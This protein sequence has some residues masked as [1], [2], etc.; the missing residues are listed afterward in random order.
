[1][2][3][4]RSTFL[5]ATAIVAAAI[6]GVASAN[7]ETVLRYSNWV[8]ATHPIVTKVIQPWGEE[9]KAATEGRVSVEVVPALGPPPGHF[10]LV[11]NEVADMAFGVHGY[12]PGR[13]TLT[14][15]VEFPGMGDSAEAMSVA[16]Q[17]IH[18]REL[19]ATNEHDGVKLLA[20]WVHGPGNIYNNQRAVT[21]VE[22]L[23]GLK[24]R[25]GGGV[26][27]ETAQA[28]G[29]TPLLRPSTES[30]E[31]ISSGIADGVLFP[32][33]SVEAFNLTKVIDHATEVPGGLYNV[34]FAM[35]MNQ[36]TFDGLSAADQDAVMS[37]SGEALARMAG[38][39][40]DRADAKA[41][42]TM[43][44]AGVQTVNAD[45]SFMDAVTARTQPLV[46]KWVE[47]AKAKGVDG[48]AM[49]D[50]YRAEIQSVT[51]GN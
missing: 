29:I 30:Y 46:A 38:Q 40:W 23:A 20:L 49:L 2:S 44:E 27:A 24:M 12:T 34:S 13:F 14:K 1:M 50:A 9:L 31:L 5:A 11:A 8:P 35:F 19:A 42:E 3:K 47:D 18:E 36:D 15:M 16:Y 41:R 10:D 48:Q 32:P 43:A 7:A 45:Q 17:R 6:A 33:E 37:V 4:T 25:V 21:S 51:A 22:D 26:S 28:L 39:A